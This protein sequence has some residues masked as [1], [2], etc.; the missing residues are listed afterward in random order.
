M[1]AFL[2]PAV[3]I[4]GMK[5]LRFHSERWNCEENTS[6]AFDTILEACKG[7]REQRSLFG[8][9]VVIHTARKDTQ[10]IE[11]HTYTK[12]AE[13]LDVVQIKLY[14]KTSGCVIKIK[15]WSSGFLPTIIPLAPLL[16]VAFF[17]FPFSGRD[18]DGWLNSRR[19]HLIK[20]K[21]ADKL[22]LKDA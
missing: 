10:Y 2:R 5:N 13:W 1:Q 8:S 14:P 12:V 19:C 18:S 4:P 9:A 17:W 6:Q 22:R 7:F 16:N 11:L 21:L 15:S 20:E 3:W